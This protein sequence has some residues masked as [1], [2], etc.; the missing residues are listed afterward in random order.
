M[1][2]FAQK[3]AD[4]LGP[5]AI[6]LAPESSFAMYKGVDGI[7]YLGKKDKT[8]EEVFPVPE[9]NYNNLKKFVGRNSN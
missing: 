6:V 8:G 4:E 1:T 9:E 7:F 5:G 3:L 2:S